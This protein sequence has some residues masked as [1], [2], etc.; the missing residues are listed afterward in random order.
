MGFH[1]GF[2]LGTLLN[3]RAHRTEPLLKASTFLPDAQ[4]WIGNRQSLF[5]QADVGYNAAGLGQYLGRLGLGSGLGSHKGNGLVVGVAANQ[6][7]LLDKANEDETPRST[8]GFAAANL[9]L[10]NSGFSL[11]PTA[12]TDFGRTAQLSL[13]LHY[14]VGLK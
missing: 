5:V 13:K 9:R 7:G 8:L 6:M 10:G 11:E 1:L 2:H 14:R 3:N 4:V 12:A